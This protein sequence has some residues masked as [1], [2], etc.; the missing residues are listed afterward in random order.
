[1]VSRLSDLF[2]IRMLVQHFRLDLIN[3]LLRHSCVSRQIFKNKLEPLA[4]LF[5]LFALVLQT[6]AF[7]FAF[8]IRLLELSKF[9]LVMVS[10]VVEVLRVFGA[11]VLSVYVVDLVDVSFAF[12]LELKDHLLN[13]FLVLVDFAS[14]TKLV[15]M[16]VFHLVLKSLDQQLFV[17]E[18]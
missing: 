13:L 6:F 5:H 15:V 18:V 16:V 1:M 2:Q 4:A 17:F 12:G 11:P 9:L 14:Q 8:R 7:L 3:F 10:S